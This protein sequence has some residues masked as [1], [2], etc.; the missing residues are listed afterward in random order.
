MK[1]LCLILFGYL[2]T[3][4]TTS[5]AQACTVGSVFKT[6]QNVQ[7]EC[8]NDPN[9]GA[10]WKAPDGLV[11]GDP[12]TEVFGNYDLAGVKPSNGVIQKSPA[13]EACK[14]IHGSL[15]TYEQYQ[16]F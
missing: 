12:L 13:T 3:L 7:L 6:N 9:F 14:A 10:A 2:I 11:W 5:S 16:T 4:T 1:K 8:I 15:P